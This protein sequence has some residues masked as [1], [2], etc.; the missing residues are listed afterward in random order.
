MMELGAD[1]QTPVEVKNTRYWMGPDVTVAKG[2]RSRV[3]DYGRVWDF[4]GKSSEVCKISW[5]GPK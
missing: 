4:D 1:R 2:T 5:S 3:R